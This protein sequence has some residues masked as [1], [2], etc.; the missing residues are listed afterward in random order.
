MPDTSLRR[1]GLLAV[2]TG[3]SSGIGYELARCC[4][5]RGYDLVIAADEP[6]IEIAARQLRDE[7]AEVT[8]LLAD[9]ATPDGVE[10]VCAALGSRRVDVLCANA[11]RGLGHAF[12]DQDFA[13]IQRVVETNVTGTLHLLHRV[14]QIMRAQHEG[15]ILI[16]GSIAGFVPGTCQAVYN[17]TKAFLDSFSYALRHELQH[18]GVS[19][20]CLMPGATETDFFER[21]DLL[22]TRLGQQKKADPAEVA[23]IGFDAMM[24]GEGEVVPGW[25]NKL[26]AAIAMVTP[27]DVL[28]EQ[29]RRMAEPQDASGSA[30]AA[31]A[32]QPPAP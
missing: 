16:T 15:R 21:A 18:T 19:V 24:R 17:A 27:A 1:T 26:R 30:P 3:A 13:A 11:G 28:A 12:L 25:Q 6:Q 31:P 8:A 14:G 9:L 4:L 10:Q 22:D 23:R 7:G 32:D 5:R 20:T 29:H 2:V